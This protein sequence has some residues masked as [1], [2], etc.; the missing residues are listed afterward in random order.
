[1]NTREIFEDIKSQLTPINQWIIGTI[2]AI[3]ML[4]IAVLGLIITIKNLDKPSTP[5]VIEQKIDSPT[6][7]IQNTRNGDSVK[8]L[9]PQLKPFP[10][11][12]DQFEVTFNTNVREELGDGLI[13][14]ELSNLRAVAS[15]FALK[16]SLLGK[17]II[18][19]Y[20][21]VKANGDKRLSGSVAFPD[22]QVIPVS[23]VDCKPDLQAAFG[24]LM[25]KYCKMF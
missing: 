23:N 19:L 14:V 12:S 15:Q 6:K 8:I 13:N 18:N 7:V 17:I 20:F 24:Y 3:C 11:V 4:I 22:G 2:I 1:M 16:R 10:K 9:L 25:Y 21:Q 5:Q